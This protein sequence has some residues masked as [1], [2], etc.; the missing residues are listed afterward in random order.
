MN[1]ALKDRVTSQDDSDVDAPVRI[2][3]EDTVDEQD[4][5][6]EAPQEKVPDPSPRPQ[7]VSTEGDA[8]LELTSVSG[9][10]RECEWVWHLA[11]P[12]YRAKQHSMQ[13]LHQ[14]I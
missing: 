12:P 3:V 4:T 6:E 14:L 11:S 7:E 8:R 5:L 1:D 13:Q 9:W 10:G 2:M